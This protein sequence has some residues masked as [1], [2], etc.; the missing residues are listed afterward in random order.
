MLPGIQSGLPGASALVCLRGYPSLDLWRLT[1]G[2][3]QTE[4]YLTVL[5]LQHIPG[6]PVLC[7]SLPCLSLPHRLLYLGL[8]YPPTRDGPTPVCRLCS[9]KAFCYHPAAR[10]TPFPY[11]IALVY[12]LCRIKFPF[13]LCAGA[14][15][16]CLVENVTVWNCSVHHP[17]SVPVM[18]SF[19]VCP[20]NCKPALASI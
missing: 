17:C 20:V 4:G 13:N 2:R 5:M 1:L 6:E 19:S 10:A 11:H 8:G 16:L 15:F 3:I 7:Q 18:A 12:F 14:W 9:P